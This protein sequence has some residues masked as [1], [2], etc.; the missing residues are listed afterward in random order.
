[1]WTD[2]FS[3]V[4][5]CHNTA[6]HKINHRCTT[7]SM[8]KSLQ[9]QLLW[10]SQFP[11]HQWMDFH[12][13]PIKFT[14]SAAAWPIYLQMHKMLHSNY[15]KEML[16]KTWWH[17]QLCCYFIRIKTDMVRDTVRDVFSTYHVDPS[18]SDC[19]EPWLMHYSICINIKNFYQ[20]LLDVKP[21]QRVNP[22]SD[23]VL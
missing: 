23:S 22:P 7:W 1:M 5:K 18:S 17:I 21:H 16:Q 6:V 2:T 12:E 14:L 15:S 9:G 8:K 19:L 4:S 20:E 10:F 11:H 13:V 3:K